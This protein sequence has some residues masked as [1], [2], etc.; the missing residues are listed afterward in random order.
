MSKKSESRTKS[1][2]VLLSVLFL[3]TCLGTAMG[4]IKQFKII[5]SFPTPGTNPN[6]LAWD[7][8]S[9]WHTDGDTK[10]I[11]HLSTTGTVLGTIPYPGSLP[12]G[13][14]WVAPSSLWISDSRDDKVYQINSANGNTISQIGTYHG[15]NWSVAWDNLYL[16][17]TDLNYAEVYKTD[18]GGTMR[19]IIPAPSK[20]I[21]GAAYDGQNL[22]LVSSD[23]HLFY[24]IDRTN[25]NILA[26]Y[27]QPALKCR[28]LTWDGS[29]LWTCGGQDYE[30]Y[31]LDLNGP[32]TCNVTLHTPNGSEEWSSGVTKEIVWSSSHA[33]GEVHIDYSNNNGAYYNEVVWRTPND[34]YFSWKIPASFSGTQYKIKVTDPF[35]TNCWDASDEGFTIVGTC[36]ITVT[37]PNGAEVW[38][39]GSTQN[40]TW[41]SYSTSGNVKLSYSLDAGATWNLITNSTPDDGSEA[42]ALPS[43]TTDQTQGRVKVEDAA[44]AACFDGSNNNFT[45]RNVPPPCSIIVTSPKGGETW[46]EN[47][48]HNI[49]WSSAN[50][51]GNVR[52][53]YSTDSGTTW[54][55]II[56]TTPDDGGYS[57]TVPEVTSTLTKCRVKVED[58]AAASCYNFSSADFTIRNIPPACSITVSSPNGGE[59]WDE[60]SAHNVTWTS[61]STSGNVKISYSINSGTTWVTIVNS[62]T[63]DGS[64]SWTV[65]EVSSTMTQ[66]RVKVEDAASAG[67]F[68]ISNANFTINNLPPPCSIN[69]TQPNGGETWN[70][71]TGHMITWTSQSSSG[72]VKLSYSLNGGAAWITILNTTPDDGQYWWVTPEVTAAQ[73]QVRVKVEDVVNPT[74]CFDVSEANFTIAEV[75]TCQI[76]IV[77]PNGGEIWAP[78]ATG[79]HSEHY[80]SWQPG[81]L[82]GNVKLEYSLNAGGSWNVITNSTENDG[83]YGWAVPNTPS[84]QV[85]VRVTSL[86]NTSC[87]DMS[88]A[89]F[90][91]G[92]CPTPY[93]TATDIRGIAGNRET[94]EIRIGGSTAPISAFGLKLSFDTSHLTLAEIQ[95]GDLT[96]AWIQVSGAEN[97]PGLITIGGFHTTAIPAGS[98]GSIAKVIF[99]VTCSGCVECDQSPLRISDLLDNLVGM[100]ICNGVFGYGSDCQL[101]DVNMDGHITPADALCA[102]Q[103]YLNGGTPTPGSACATECGVESAD[104]NCNGTITPQDALLIFQAYLSGATSMQCPSGMAKAAD[105]NRMLTIS[106]AIGLPGDEVKIPIHVDDA[107]DLSAF[108]LRLSYPAEMLKFAGI[109]RGKL[110]EKWVALDASSEQTGEILVGGFNPEAIDEKSAGELLSLKFTV[111]EEATGSARLQVLEVSDDLAAAAIQT[112]A[113]NTQVDGMGPETYGLAQNHPNPFNMATEIVYRL[114]ES[115]RV[116]MRIVDVMGRQVRSLESGEMEA[117]IHR[118]TWDGLDSGGHALPTGIYVCIL[119]TANENYSIKMLLM[120]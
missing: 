49:T 44:D 89:N 46:D 41:T 118:V 80:I 75:P 73:T 13:I 65:P 90:T 95:K 6:D 92:T 82:S 7:G 9:L 39:E 74:T 8:T 26:V 87:T 35:N 20:R 4:Q 76:A 97:T 2:V 103:T 107:L 60:N 40:V 64:Y 109:E 117:G 101:G 51:S 63:D 72:N 106:D 119:Q 66:S 99:T 32:S 34:G 78:D 110:T 43:V 91:I 22:W 108:G 61:V 111:K 58:A 56:N 10:T 86:L 98:S 21:E 42:W 48:A 24:K 30:I 14:T 96:S 33:S 62:T 104:A 45:V 84:N 71:N 55:A 54:T 47:T 113:I 18:I 77:F 29:H 52:I 12:C 120:K 94:V 23:D 69:V 17:L 112:G 5:K 100:N 16:W 88:D 15:L 67:C 19:G 93:I 37:S 38:D 36:G 70:E 27:G 79:S 11:Y 85:R 114:R 31:E 102:F 59:S 81:G 83:C 115:G 3:L 50:T 1:I 25:G 57:W 28:G 68:D 105:R 53:A 116:E